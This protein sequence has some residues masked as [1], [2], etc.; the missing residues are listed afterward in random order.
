[1]E[2]ILREGPNLDPSPAGVGEGSIP[3]PETITDVVMCLQ[4]GT[5]HGCPLRGPTSS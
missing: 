3:R 1:M 5:W 4:L 2:K